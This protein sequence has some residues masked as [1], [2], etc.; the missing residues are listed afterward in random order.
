MWSS[1]PSCCSSLPARLPGYRYFPSAASSVSTASAA[2]SSH[3]P[4]WEPQHHNSIPTRIASTAPLVAAAPELNTEHLHAELPIH[5]MHSRA[6]VPAATS[7]A[8]A[9]PEWYLHKP[10]AT[11]SAATVPPGISIRYLSAD[12]LGRTV[13]T[14][15]ANSDL[16][17]PPGLP[18]VPNPVLHKFTGFVPAFP[19]GSTSTWHAGQ[20]WR[21]A[22][23]VYP[24]FITWW[25]WR[26][27]KNWRDA[28]TR[29]FTPCCQ[30]APATEPGQWK[31]TGQ[32][33][34]SEP[35]GGNFVIDG[36]SEGVW[37]WGQYK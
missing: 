31:S 6:A 4:H 10:G 32:Q 37:C 26:W 23:A 14:T 36:V 3:I 29:P 35:V 8:A 7:A 27:R 30:Q 15:A 22:Y 17:Y 9:V 12:W 34:G 13:H 11:I 28:V 18:C 5:G 2:A 19:A 20:W 16:S 21:G 25:Y 24:T 33:E 1:D